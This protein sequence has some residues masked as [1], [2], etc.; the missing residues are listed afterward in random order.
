[1]E[2]MRGF[3][4]SPIQADNSSPRGFDQSHT[5]DTEMYQPITQIVSITIKCCRVLE[6]L[7]LDFSNCCMFVYI[8]FYV[9]DVTSSSLNLAITMVI[10]VWVSTRSPPPLNDLSQNMV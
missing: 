9:V 3:G 10:L 7:G 6:F 2:E 1:M 5:E 8:L 4:L